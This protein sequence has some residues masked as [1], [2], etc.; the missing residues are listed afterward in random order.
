MGIVHRDIKP[1][2]IFMSK[3]QYAVVKLGD[4]GAAQQL[5]YSQQPLVGGVH[6]PPYSAPER[7]E[8]KPYNKPVDIY[9]LGVTLY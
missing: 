7:L 3:D 6:T 1:L 4:L 5:D 8:G 2:N 9:A